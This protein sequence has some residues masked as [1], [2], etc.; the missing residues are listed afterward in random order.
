MDVDFTTLRIPFERPL[1]LAWGELEER[2]LI[3]LRLAGSDGVI[4][5]GEAAPLEPYDGVSLRRVRDA[6]ETYEPI[7]RA[8]AAMQAA[9]AARD[10]FSCLKLKVGLGDDHGR[11]AAVRAAVGPDVELRLDANG[12]WDVDE[13]VAAIETL[14]PA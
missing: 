9:M 7:L 3:V 14:A 11:V 5:W 13:A 1:R 2:E 8:G 12:V 6:L 10:G 4:G